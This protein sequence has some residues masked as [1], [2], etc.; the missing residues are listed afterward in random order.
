MFRCRLEADGQKRVDGTARGKDWTAGVKA[1][2]QTRQRR[3]EAVSNP[4]GGCEVD[5]A[6]GSSG[7][8]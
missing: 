5:G 7:Q 8:G 3:T 6:C 4:N 2:R 1:Q